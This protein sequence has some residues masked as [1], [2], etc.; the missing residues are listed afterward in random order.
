MQIQKEYSEDLAFL[1]RRLF[2]QWKY[3]VIVVY[4]NPETGKTDFALLMVEIAKDLGV[5][6]SFASN[7]NTYDTGETITSLEEENYW[8]E[9]QAGTKCMVLDEAGVHDDSR[10][11]LSRLNREIRHGVFIIRKFKGHKIFILQELE[12]LDKWK[13]SELTGAF[14]KKKTFE[15]EFIASIKTRWD[16]D[17]YVFRDIPKTTIPYNTLDVA[18][19]TLERQIGDREV[20]LK[21]LPYEIAF[22]Y[23][24]CGNLSVVAKELE[25]KLGKLLKHTQAKRLLMQFCRE[26]LRIKVKKGRP[27]KPKIETLL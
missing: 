19:Y 7:I 1:V 22:R 18:P 4:G 23:A 16:A 26:Q 21:G 24:K 27:L 5:L 14:V 12:D 25:P 3:P 9:H 2:N 10:S 20:S 15:N 8:F 11:P 13:H 6:D 17:L